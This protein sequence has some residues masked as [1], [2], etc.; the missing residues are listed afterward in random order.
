[1]SLDTSGNYLWY[2]ILRNFFDEK[3]NKKNKH[4]N[5]P[6]DKVPHQ[7]QRSDEKAWFPIMRQFLLRVMK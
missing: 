3:S 2:L 6:E 4:L 1:M 7:L 5:Q